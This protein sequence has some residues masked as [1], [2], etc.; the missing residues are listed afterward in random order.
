MYMAQEIDMSH[1]L[2]PVDLHAYTLLMCMHG[3][4]CQHRQY[5][6]CVTRELV[7]E[8]RQGTVLGASGQIFGSE[9]Y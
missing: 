5:I 3:G 1:Y 8:Q 2:F 9:I 6:S 4:Q 7:L